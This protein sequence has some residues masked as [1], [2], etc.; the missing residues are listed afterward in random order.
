MPELIISDFLNKFRDVIK[1][2][3]PLTAFATE[4]YG[5]APFVFVGIDVKEP[6]DE[7]TMPHIIL[8][9]GDPSRSG[10]V[11]DDSTIYRVDIL[12]AVK[13]DG[14]TPS[15]YGMEADGVVNCDKFG[16]LIWDAVKHFS[17]NCPASRVDYTIE[18]AAFVPI[19]PGTMTIEIHVPM[20]MGAT[21]TI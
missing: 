12:F 21:I 15:N 11:E 4:K 10:G 8:L 13:D 7:E 16:A 6:P 5:K 2:D 1:A 17:S 9:P 19:F 20:V 3:V 18:G 14:I